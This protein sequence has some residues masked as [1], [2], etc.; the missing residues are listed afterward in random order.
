MPRTSGCKRVFETFR[1][2]RWKNWMR[3]DVAVISWNMCGAKAIETNALIESTGVEIS[4]G[5]LAIQGFTN[6]RGAEEC[7][8]LWHQ[9]YLGKPLGRRKRAAVKINAVCGESSRVFR[10][11]HVIAVGFERWGVVSPYLHG[12]ATVVD[13]GVQIQQQIAAVEHINFRGDRNNFVLRG[14]DMN[15]VVSRTG[16]EHWTGNVGGRVCRLGE[17]GKVNIVMKALETL[18]MMLVNSFIDI[19][20]TRITWKKDET[21]LDIS[22]L[23][24]QGRSRI[25][26]VGCS[27]PCSKVIC[28]KLGEA[29]LATRTDHCSIV[30][31]AAAGHEIDE[32]EFLET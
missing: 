24:D 27:M 20:P 6:R 31:F 23:G 25:D 14:F 30:L 17:S 18:S 11:T 5:A 29:K 1:L 7:K 32:G 13:V 26:Y 2:E 22:T 10:D 15:C 4:W 28:R 19:G 8:N 9:T 3:P 12:S 21:N 16:A